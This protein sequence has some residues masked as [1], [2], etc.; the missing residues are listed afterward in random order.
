MT[1]SGKT[2]TVSPQFGGVAIIGMS[3]LFPG[4]PNLDAYWSNI[5]GG[6]DSVSEPPPES[7][8]PA[9]SF[10]PD[11]R[12]TDRIYCQR[13][14][15][16][17]A[18]TTFDPLSHGVP[19]V[20][21][22]GEPDQWLA[23]Q[24]AHDALQDAGRLDLDPAIR[25][26]T[27]V[28]LG[29][30]TYLNA[31]NAIAVQ[32]GLVV[33]QTLEIVRRLHPELGEVELQAIRDELKRGLPPIN[34]ETVPGLIPNVI[35]G[36]IANRLDLMGPSY[37][38]DAACAS[39]IVAVQH[40]IKDLI[41]GACDLALV[42]GSQVWIPMPTM[43]IFCQLGA[44]SRRQRIRPFD[45]EADGTLLG[46]GIGM[47]VL[48]RVEDAERD[49]DRVYA[50]IRGVGVASDGRGT[51][52]MAPRVEGEELALRL[53]YEAAGVDPRTVGLIEA[54]GTGTP[55][56][57]VIEVRAMNRVFGPLSGELPRCAIGSVKSMIGH[58]IPAAGVAG[59]IKTALALY[60]KV[61][62]PTLHCEQPNPKLELDRT[63]F[64]LNTSARPWIHGAPE[65]RRAGVNAFGFGGING[66][67]VLQEHSGASDAAP[68]DHLPDR[69]TDV[70]ILDAETREA[71]ADAA[72]EWSR[73]IAS[74][75]GRE[76]APGRPVR[77]LDVACHMNDH[78]M[79]SGSAN[80]H[81]L[82]IVASSLG[83]LREKMERAARKLE[84]PKGCRQIREPSGVY[85]ASE[86]LARSGKV[87]ML[88][89]GE[90]SQYP[91]MLTDLCLHFP[92]VRECF[93][94]ID[95]VYHEHD[96][97]YLPS[98][99]IF[100]HRLMTHEGAR[101]VSGRLWEIAGA[102]EA[103][104]T[105]NQAIHAILTRLG[106][107]PDVIVGHSTGEFSA[108]RAAGILDPASEQL[109]PFI[110]DLYRNYEEAA[111]L[112]VPKAVLL[113]V[114]ADR[115]AVEAVAREVGNG[116][117]VAMDN[118]PHQA[119]LVGGA[120]ETDRAIE[121]L[122]RDGLIYERL[123]FDRAYHTPRFAPYAEHLRRIFE[124]AN[125]GPPRIPVVSCTTA[126]PYPSEP[127]AIRSLMVN[128]WLEPVEFRKTVE[129]LHDQG[130]RVFIESGP[131]GN[132]TAF[133]DDILRGRPYCA[134]PA[135]VQRRSGVT[136]I[137]HLVAIL[138]AQ[139]MN[140]DLSYLVRN[141]RPSPL[142]NTESP[143]APAGAPRK[144]ATGFPAMELTPAFVERLR[145]RGAAPRSDS[146]A[147]SAPRSDSP[148]TSA[149][150]SPDS[151]E[152]LGDLDRE[153]TSTHPA[154]RMVQHFLQTM[155]RFLLVQDRVMGDCL[156]RRDGS[157]EVAGDL[158][159]RASL[160]RFPL[161][162][163]DVAVT[164]EGEL[165]VR[166]VVDPERDLYL[167]DHTLGHVHSSTEPELL[168]LSMMPLTMTLEML[169]EAAT[170]LRPGCVVVGA[171][172]VIAS[173]WVAFDGEPQELEVRAQVVPGAPDK[174]VVKLRNLTEDREADRP[175]A[176]P[177]VQALVELAE[178]YPDS[179]IARDWT[180]ANARPSRQ[181]PD[182]L[183]QEAMFHGPCWQGV[184]SVDLVGDDGA[185]ATLRVLSADDFFSHGVAP[186]FVLDPIVLDA[187]GQLVGFWTVERL[188]EGKVVFPYRL[189]SL[190][191]FGGSRPRGERLS[192][193]ASIQLVGSRQVRSTIEVV[194]GENRV[195]LRLVGWE[196]RRF[197]LPPSLEPL[198]R[199]NPSAISVARPDVARMLPGVSVARACALSR[200]VG[201]DRAFWSRVWACRV[202]S[203]RERD[204]F[205]RLN[206]DDEQ[207]LAWLAART[208]AKEAVKSLLW[209]EYQRF[210][211]A[212]EIEINDWG[213]GGLE[214][215]GVW[216][217][218]VEDEPIVVAL[219]SSGEVFA[220]AAIPPLIGDETGIC[221]LGLGMAVIE[222]NDDPESALSA[223]ARDAVIQAMIHELDPDTP[224]AIESID[225][226]TGLVSIRIA[227]PS[228]ARVTVE[229]A[230]VEG[231]VVAS[232]LVELCLND[233]PGPQRVATW[234]S[235]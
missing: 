158:S 216:S 138:S 42:G 53:A 10:D 94:Q 76:V 162:G 157:G 119:V 38:V 16:L 184:E 127:D 35:V 91:D 128:H 70:I 62:P 214:A 28:I 18:L 77:L 197:D 169:A 155:E 40:A 85:Y 213:A 4:A 8:E 14:G 34:P 173:R 235:Q 49:G 109:G 144:L 7:R 89:P 231:V 11:S 50:V 149:A 13:G 209:D 52:V 171:R 90:G 117:F 123:V 71:L 73:R 125:I 45:K 65:P 137:N 226:N 232:A 174:V 189:E 111:R 72:L 190:E 122:R 141:R 81:R 44:L 145:P 196:D 27:A 107:V 103:V 92:E 224:M 25:R 31:G 43:S 181:S 88:F 55:V 102:V 234:T 33:G 164:S 180:P 48:K 152:S 163:D 47:L 140:L 84:T 132:L 78:A 183:Y 179:P 139:G 199:P 2:T 46:E 80:A 191:V 168:A 133:V 12:D 74:L 225:R 116:I 218:D 95:A 219:E 105:A 134:I 86:P 135:N 223:A 203:T 159:P 57:D 217:D 118:C 228:P 67:V 148:A 93:D 147:T 201:S 200:N 69:E 146:P 227:A 170:A 83:D 79:T 178:G 115:M 113:A 29:K 106:V 186:N 167:K 17:G 205:R 100:P 177:V 1:D 19:P 151:S 110:L 15:Y 108:V 68:L 37:T 229:T 99:H 233:A 6:V 206:V 66:H 51:S 114:G 101:R 64:Y 75:E 129:T 3:C 187:A 202:L 211:D 212:T 30:G 5:L 131:R 39:S 136:Q 104:L 96:R 160:S 36:R 208:V 154:T 188:S 21:V 161:L 124:S 121:I 56:G 63:P 41:S 22:G 143:V 60:H 207:R 58:T 195:W 20:S 222:A 97:G 176:S 61:L 172:D 82:A 26:R 126:A 32:H 54:H 175:L 220:I 221:R 120:E 98:D 87:A 204:E 185:T 24:L 156:G 23:L 165:V 166:R 142:P 182:R 150:S 194:D 192:C 230:C 215:T 198:I 193:R 59:I 153:H 9:N 130:V 210:V 112:G